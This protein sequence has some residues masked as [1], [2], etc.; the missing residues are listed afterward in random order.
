MIRMMMLYILYRFRPSSRQNVS[1]RVASSSKKSVA[2]ESHQRLSVSCNTV[3]HDVYIWYNISTMCCLQSFGP[4]GDGGH[5]ACK[6]LKCWYDGGADLTASGAN[7]LHISQ[8]WLSPLPL[9][10][11]SC[12]SKTPESFDTQDDQKYSLLNWCSHRPTVYLAHFP[13]PV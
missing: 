10:S 11:V 5:P 3:R 13:A 7:N 9:P 8:L 4:A 12:C 2:N 1:V 6:N